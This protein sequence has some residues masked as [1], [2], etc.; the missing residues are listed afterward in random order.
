MALIHSHSKNPPS[1]LEFCSFLIIKEATDI[2][3]L[4]VDF[5]FSPGRMD[6]CI[7]RP[8]LSEASPPNLYFNVW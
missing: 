7:S 8:C 4:L 2:L 6:V 5:R 3:V 1:S